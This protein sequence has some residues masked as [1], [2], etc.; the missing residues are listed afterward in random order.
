MLQEIIDRSLFNASSAAIAMSNSMRGNNNNHFFRL[1]SQFGSNNS[2]N[3]FSNGFPSNNSNYLMQNGN[4]GNS[5]SPKK[6]SRFSGSN[7]NPLNINENGS[8]FDLDEQQRRSN[9]LANSDDIENNKGA[10][11]TVVAKKFVICLLNF[12][13]I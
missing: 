2:N 12:K 7:N 4:S 11:V 10:G 9:N 5:C 1:Q 8:R 3:V 13:I 6:I